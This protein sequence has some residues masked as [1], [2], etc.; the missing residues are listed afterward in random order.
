[1]PSTRA[2]WKNPNKGGYEAMNVLVWIVAG[3]A[4]GFFLRMV[5]GPKGEGGSWTPLIVGV[6]GGVIGG[7]LA[8]TYG[9]RESLPASIVAALAGAGVLLLAWKLYAIRSQATR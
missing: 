1:M 2:G 9:R 8:L 5:L 3:L 6:I 7:W 4:A